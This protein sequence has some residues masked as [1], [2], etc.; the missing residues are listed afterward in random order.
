MEDKVEASHFDR[1]TRLFSTSASRRQTIG[2]LVSGVLVVTLPGVTAGTGRT[3]QGPVTPN[4]AILN[5]FGC[6]DVGQACKNADECCSGRCRGKGKKHCK[7]HDTGGCKA[8]EGQCSQ[9]AV[10]C[11]TSK[12]NDGD[13]ATTTGN[14]GFCQDNGGCQ[15]CTRDRDCQ[16]ST[17]TRAAACIVCSSCHE[18]T[19]CVVA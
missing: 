8:G 2:A 1:M 15:V 9:A 17:N 6:L 18:G 13:C 3:K 14:A 5:G 10:P 4:G 12:G 16:I 11:R 7:A 19:A